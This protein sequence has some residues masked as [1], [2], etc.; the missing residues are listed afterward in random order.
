M[1]IRVKKSSGKLFIKFNMLSCIITASESSENCVFMRSS[2]CNMIQFLY[3]FRAVAFENT[4][5][6]YVTS[7]LQLLQRHA[8][9]CLAWLRK[10]F[11]L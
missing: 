3:F 7:E 11:Q 9:S 10:T 1:M 2:L 4:T 5:G 8:E 6:A